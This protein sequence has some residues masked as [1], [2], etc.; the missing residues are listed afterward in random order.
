MSDRISGRLK[1][2][3]FTG[4]T[5]PFELGGMRYIPYKH[6]LLNK[7]IT[8]LGIPS[9]SF[10]MNGD[11]IQNYMRKA[12]LRNDYYQMSEWDS[13][14]K[15]DSRLLTSYR[16]KGHIVGMTAFQIISFSLY[17]ILTA[18][19][20]FGAMVESFLSKTPEDIQ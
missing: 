7:V 12:Y 11:P 18:P 8:D 4:T 3:T 19:E 6:I 9:I 15:N 13:N 16:M 1:S 17:L 20:N 10:P 5:T 14:Q 2:F